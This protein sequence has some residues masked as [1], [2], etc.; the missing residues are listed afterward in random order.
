MCVCVCVCVCVCEIGGSEGSVEVNT[1]AYILRA[2]FE[3][4]LV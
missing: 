4:G 1:M 3:I 2:E